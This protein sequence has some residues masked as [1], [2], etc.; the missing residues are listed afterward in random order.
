[1][2]DIKDILLSPETSQMLAESHKPLI[3]EIGNT[4]IVGELHIKTSSDPEIEK[5]FSQKIN[6]VEFVV[7]EHKPLANDPYSQQSTA[8]RFIAQ[9]YEH[10]IESGKQMTTLDEEFSVSDRYN[11]WLNAGVDISVIITTYLGGYTY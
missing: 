10:A 5:D 6:E 8:K 1:M 11:I 9:A 2:Q 3:I 4:T 7:L